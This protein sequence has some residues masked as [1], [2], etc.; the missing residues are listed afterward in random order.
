M[1]VNSS[2][3]EFFGAK[4]VY[5][6]TEKKKSVKLVGGAWEENN[7]LYWALFFNCVISI[8]VWTDLHIRWSFYQH[9][10]LTRRI[11]HHCIPKSSSIQICLGDIF[12]SAWQR[13]PQCLITQTSQR[14]REEMSRAEFAV[15][16]LLVCYISWLLLKAWKE[17]QHP[18]FCLLFPL[19]VP[20]QGQ[21]VCF[22]ACVFSID[23]LSFI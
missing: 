18:N 5:F 21:P 11:L 17:G 8:R 23:W 3:P 2:N 16:G 1:Q 20:L 10:I 4:G 9:L 22:P 19:V 13:F 6:V 14:R 7:L 12:L 15:P